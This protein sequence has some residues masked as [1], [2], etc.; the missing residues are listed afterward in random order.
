MRWVKKYCIWSHIHEEMNKQN[1]PLPFSALVPVSFSLVKASLKLP[2]WCDV[3]FNIL[4]SIMFFR[5]WDLTLEKKERSGIGKIR[6]KKRTNRERKEK[7]MN[8]NLPTHTFK[9]TYRKCCRSWLLNTEKIS[10]K[11]RVDLYGRVKIQ[12]FT[13]TRGT[14]LLTINWYHLL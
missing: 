6:M 10:T 14:V 9:D 2:F 7:Q 12:A 8:K 5:S 4:F 1:S 11:L 13:T 3:S